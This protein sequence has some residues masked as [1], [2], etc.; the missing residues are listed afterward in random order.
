MDRV[1]VRDEVEGGFELPHDVRHHLRFK[2]SSFGSVISS[3]A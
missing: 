1:D 3:M 2:T